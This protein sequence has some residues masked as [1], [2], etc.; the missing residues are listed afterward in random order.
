[1]S[2]VDHHHQGVSFES[3]VLNL[4]SVEAGGEVR[5]STWV[6]FTQQRSTSEKAPRLVSTM[7]NVLDMVV[8]NGELGF[9]I[10]GPD[11]NGGQL[12]RSVKLQDSQGEYS[13]G[14]DSRGKPDM[15]LSFSD[16]LFQNTIQVQSFGSPGNEERH[17]SLG[18]SCINA[19]LC[20][21]RFELTGCK[22]CCRGFFVSVNNIYIESGNITGIRMDSD[23]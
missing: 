21:T 17:A 23:D 19:E 15:L 4:V 22:L 3:G 5:R 1:M 14:S 11:P 20:K 16:R 9:S 18:P 2:L 12:F 6:S 13:L 10:A 7:G 8:E